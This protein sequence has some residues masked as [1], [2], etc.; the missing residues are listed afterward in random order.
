MKFV[1]IIALA[2]IT[3][4]HSHGHHSHHDL[5]TEED[6]ASGHRKLQNGI[7]FKVGDKTWVNRKAFEDGARCKTRQL[8]NEEVEEDSK[9]VAD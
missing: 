4:V 1:L 8:T 5:R 2:S 6:E 7:P 3:T 9:K